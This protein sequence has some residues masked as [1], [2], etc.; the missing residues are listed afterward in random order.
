[1][2]RPAILRAMRLPDIR[3][4]IAA[5]TTPE[6]LDQLVDECDRRRS[7]GAAHAARVARLRCRAIKAAATRRAREAERAPH[8]KPGRQRRPLSLVAFL[9]RAGGIRDP[10][11]DLRAVMGTAKARVGLLNNRSGRGLDDAARLALAAGYFPEHVT[12][13]RSAIVSESLAGAMREGGAAAETMT[14]AVLLDA[15]DLELRGRKRWPN[16]EAPAD[17][18]QPDPER[19][20]HDR[21]AAT[22]NAAL[23]WERLCGAAE[24]EGIEGVYSF[25]FA[26]NVLTQ[27][28][29]IPW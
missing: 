7:A 29:D 16:G 23:L 13:F 21:D 14:P 1:V 15:I 19:E 9:V 28:Q 17:L 26:R 11:G 4:R 20:Q 25:L 6:Q 18:A 8:I 22:R 12:S 2:I 3:E 27:E 5:A 10:R 24:A